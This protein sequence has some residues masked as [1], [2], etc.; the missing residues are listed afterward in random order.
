MEASLDKK[1]I[2]DEDWKEQARREKEMLAEALEKEQQARRG[3]MQP[4]SFAVLAISLATQASIG[5]GDIEHRITKKC[6]P[7]LDEAKFHIDMLEILEQKTKG[8]LTP[9]EAQLMQGFL[10]DLRMRFVDKAKSSG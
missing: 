1:L 2:I 5:L 9:E 10:F 6:E 3:P 7:N 4:A 8:N